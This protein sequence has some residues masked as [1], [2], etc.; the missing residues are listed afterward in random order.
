M[1]KK[2]KN[3]VLLG[4]PGTG[5]GTQA[6]NIS[7]WFGIPHISTGDIF[8]SNIKAGT[9]LGITAKEY[10]DA[11]RL[12]PDDIT[13][14]LVAARIREAD[15]AEGF[16]LDGFP[17]SIPQAE[18]LEKIL[19]AA[20]ADIG[21]VLGIYVADETIVQR[22]SGRRLCGKCGKPY[23]T[24]YN[25]PSKDGVCDVCG[26]GVV[27][28]DDDRE[29]TIRERLSVYYAQTAPLIERYRDRGLYIQVTG[30]ELVED[31]TKETFEAIHKVFGE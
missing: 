9:E 5:K 16:I 28:R 3:I 25:P 14:G 17:R 4:A 6:E 10:I 29:S 21:T 23:H 19:A 13:I 18:A 31:T 12:V 1:N 20:G 24:V 26:G 22:L 27:Q 30:R 2:I 15:C 11:G 8:R 7:K